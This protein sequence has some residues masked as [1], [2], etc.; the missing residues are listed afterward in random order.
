VRPG[1]LDIQSAPSDDRGAAFAAVRYTIAANRT[2]QSLTLKVA[3]DSAT[4]AVLLA[5]RTGSAWSPADAG[6][7][8]TAPTVD[9]KACVNG[10]KANDGKTWT[11]AVGTLQLETIIDIAIVPGV[12][13]TAKT[14]TPFS[15]VFD[16]PSN[17]SVATID[18]TPSSVRMSSP[19]T[20]PTAIP[21]PRAPQP[22]ATALPTD[23]IGETATAPAKQVASSQPTLRPGPATT[24]SASRRDKRLGYLLI[25]LAAACAAYAWWRDRR[26]ATNEKAPRSS[27]RPRG[28]GRFTR[29]RL[30]EPPSLA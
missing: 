17:D 23:K 15:I 7:W 5:C 6:T 10:T 12:D 11:F 27:D 24:A 2:A 14:Q 21:P 4:P 25:A 30:G 20:G 1:Q 28:L 22:V 16:G 18:V 19:P 3:N 26:T 13:P 9:T 29:P 8:S